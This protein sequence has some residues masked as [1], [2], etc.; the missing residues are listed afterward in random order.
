M[1][2]ILH[3]PLEQS[4]IWTGDFVSLLLETPKKV[5]S[6]RLLLLVSPAPSKWSPGLVPGLCKWA[7]T[8]SPISNP[9]CWGQHASPPQATTAAGREEQ[10][11]EQGAASCT[12]SISLER[13]SGGSSHPG[14][15]PGAE[16]DLSNRNHGHGSP[17]NPSFLCDQPKITK[18]FLGIALLLFL[19]KAKSCS[20]IGTEGRTFPAQKPHRDA[21]RHARHG[22]YGG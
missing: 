16:P 12:L 9:S 22:T 21:P 11:T 5:C 6:D 13:L 2:Q 1:D 14:S 3:H 19:N 7:P 18:A 8:S 20:A 4:G 10:G 15:A 17:D